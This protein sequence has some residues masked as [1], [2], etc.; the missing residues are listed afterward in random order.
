MILENGSTWGFLKIL[1]LADARFV[2]KG[3][4]KMFEHYYVC[5]CTCGTIVKR[6]SRSIYLKKVNSCISCSMKQTKINQEK[7]GVHSG[8]N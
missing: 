3:A 1:N 6:A 7:I 8:S 5:E 4:H 2:S